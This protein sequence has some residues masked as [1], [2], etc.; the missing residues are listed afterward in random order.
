MKQDNICESV[1]YRSSGSVMVKR[2]WHCAA[3]PQGCRTD[4]PAAGFLGPQIHPCIAKASFETV[5][6]FMGSADWI[7]WYMKSLLFPIICFSILHLSR[8]W[9]Q[10]WTWAKYK[11]KSITQALFLTWA[12]G[13]RSRVNYFCS[14]ILRIA[15]YPWAY[16][17]CNLIGLKIYKTGE[18]TSKI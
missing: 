1:Y 3:V 17:Q 11:S 4:L 18:D 7:D 10:T 2:A 15:W 8:W 14:F 13:S 9:I 5:S 12:S 6:I 16:I